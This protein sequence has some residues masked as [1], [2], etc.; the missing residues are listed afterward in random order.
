MNNQKLALTKKWNP[1][2]Y[3]GIKKE[4]SRPIRPKIRQ[5]TE[6]LTMPTPSR[7]LIG[8]GKRMDAA[9]IFF[10]LEN[11]TECSAELGNEKTLYS[12]DIIIPQIIRIIRHWKGEIE[13]NTGDGVMA[14]VGT[15]TRDHSVIARDAI[16]IAM[17]IRYLMLVD[18]NPFLEKKG[19][20]GFS[21]RIGIDMGTVLIANIGIKSNSFLTVVG[22]A[23]NR[24]S[25]LQEI[26]TINGI[27]I[28]NNLFANLHSQ[29][30]PFCQEIKHNSWDFKY[31]E[32]NMPYRCF[33]LT[34]NWPHPREWLK[35]RLQSI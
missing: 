14:I 8:S 23:A 9:I 35:T 22:D 29:V 31:I 34:S 32:T 5:I 20:Q 13:K 3:N 25:K 4:I 33:K 19:I 17:T 21:F 7:V 6:G 15:E 2:F 10:D 27:F 16:E 18:I 30:Q 11:F 24:A 1:A 28:G 12:L 26:A